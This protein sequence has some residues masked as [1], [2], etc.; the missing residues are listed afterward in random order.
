MSPRT[1]GRPGAVDDGG[2]ADQQLEHGPILPA[3]PAVRG[4]VPPTVDGR[5]PASPREIVHT[6]RSVTQGARPGG[7]RQGG[8]VRR[9][10]RRP[11]APPAGEPLEAGVGALDGLAGEAGPAVDVLHEARAGRLHDPAD[12][13]VGVD[14]RVGRALEQAGGVGDGHPTRAEGAAVAVLVDLVQEVGERPVELGLGVVAQDPVVA[15]GHPGRAAVADAG[16]GVE[17]PQG[18]DRLHHAV[19]P[20]GRP[21]D[22]TRPERPHPQL[23]TA[24]LQRARRHH[25][26]VELGVAGTAVERPAVEGGPQDAQA[27][28]HEAEAI[29]DR[30]PERGEFL[31]PVARPDAEAE[32]PAGEGV[33]GQG[34]RGQGHRV[35]QRQDHHAGADLDPLG[36]RA[37]GGCEGERGWRVPVGDE[38]VLGDPHAPVAELLGPGDLVER[39]PV[40]AI[41]GE[42]PGR[43]VAEVEVEPVG[44]R[45]RHV[46]RPLRTAPAGGWGRGAGGGSSR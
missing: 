32:A 7:G 31:G 14:E 26:A 23:G 22:P 39:L 41:P 33:D 9:G 2:P 29:G 37:D 25:H 13:L 3:R 5:P 21:F 42:A 19:G 38:V 28:L 12:G 27:V 46:A 36:A 1:A 35:V 24:V 34:V 18:R 43:G 10:R 40:E 4:C 45:D 30:H 44:G 15:G 6:A 17:R 16:L 20:A 8:A 11:G